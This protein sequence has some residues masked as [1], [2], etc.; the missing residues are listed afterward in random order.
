MIVMLFGLGALVEQTAVGI[1]FGEAT[2][3]N[4]RGLPT[5]VRINTA[6]SGCSKNIHYIMLVYDTVAM[7]EER[8]G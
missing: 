8:E 4:A 2:D 7:E 6:N 3:D 1:Q 5:R